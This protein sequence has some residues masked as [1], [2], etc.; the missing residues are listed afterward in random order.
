MGSS[1]AGDQARRV[2]RMRLDT[3]A[4]LSPNS[5]STIEIKM[6]D[7]SESGFRAHCEARVRPGSG[8]TLEIPGIGAVE[9]QVEWQRRDQFGARFV[10]PIDISR[11]GWTLVERS[12]VLAD[13]LVERAQAQQ[14]GRKMAEGQLR[15]II[16]QALPMHK[17]NAA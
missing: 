14:A 8:V 4:R 11:C 7:L 13:L 9:A 16:L 1:I 17:D 2:E 6:I 12:H 5:W 15:R 3:A 10:V